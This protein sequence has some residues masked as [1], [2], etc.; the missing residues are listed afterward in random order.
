MSAQLRGLFVS[1]TGTSEGKTVVSRA[2]VAAA[3]ASGLR[4]AGLKPIETGCVPMPQDAIALAN[5]SGDIGLAHHAGWYRA[6]LPV[7]PYAA[8][9]EVG[10]P[11]P[12]PEQ[13]RRAVLEIMGTATYEAVLVEGAG[14]LHVPLSRTK[15][16]ADLVHALDLPVLLVAENKLGVLSHVLATV[17]AAQ[18]RGVRIAAVVL[19]EGAAPR[20]DESA[21]TNQR[22]LSERLDCPVLQFPSLG[23]ETPAELAEAASSSGLLRVALAELDQV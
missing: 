9:I 2:V 16:I 4:I 5:L 11:S 18:V 15:L 12:E 1:S 22:V 20:Q 23:G 14:G 19:N 7:S 3:R 13:L 17:E 21:R 10:Q 8:E 6:E